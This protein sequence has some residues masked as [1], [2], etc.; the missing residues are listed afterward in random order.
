MLC[1][2]EDSSILFTI[3]INIDY[4]KLMN[5]RCMY[6]CL[7]PECLKCVICHMSSPFLTSTSTYR[8]ST[9]KDKIAEN[10]LEILLLLTET[11]WN[12]IA[13]VNYNVDTWN[14]ISENIKVH[15]NR[16]QKDTK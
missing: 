10:K 5:M 11:F 2:A 15:T 3:S 9:T 4:C 12:K 8:L 6:N 1:V 7:S 14:N 13:F 16:T